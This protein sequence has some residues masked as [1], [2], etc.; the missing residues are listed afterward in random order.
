MFLPAIPAFAQVAVGVGVGDTSLNVSG[1]TSPSAYVT[2]TKDNNIIGTLTADASGNFSQS[3]PAQDPGI[4]Q[5]G[6]IAQDSA[7]RVTDAISLQVNLQEHFPTDVQVFLPTNL[8]ISP[9]IISSGQ[10]VTV[11][12]QAAPN[13]TIN[14]NLDGHAIATQSTDA[15]GNWQ[16]KLSTN[17]LAAGIHQIVATVT[18]S[19]GNQSYPTSPYEFNINAPPAGQPRSGNPPP[20]ILKLAIPKI[21]SPQPSQIITS[22]SLTIAGKGPGRTQIEVWNDTHILGSVWSDLLGNWQLSLTFNPGMYTLRSRACLDDS[23]GQFSP[24]VT[25]TYKTP[26]LT[27][28]KLKAS[29]NQ[30]SLT[31]P[32]P[33]HTVIKLNISF[34][35]AP[36]QVAVTWGD[37]TTDQSKIRNNETIL[38]HIYTKIGRYSGHV[39]V[40]DQNGKQ[41]LYFT[42][43]V[44]KVLPG[45]QKPSPQSNLVLLLAIIAASGYLWYKFKHQRKR[46]QPPAK[47]PRKRKKT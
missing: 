24:G 4:T 40:S 28:Q 11:G 25:F 29:L 22:P 41:I 1:Q 6:F 23:C 45:S 37:G 5:I 32:V 13:A 42:I 18:D 8:Q 47:K 30:Y 35:T 10:Q 14:I 38:E 43:N 2:V 44:R 26:A 3:F 15:S 46:K 19:L 16:Y 33:G 17:G 7:S 34:G 39:S 20:V 21:T 9:N 12:G 36:Y 27:Q 31:Q